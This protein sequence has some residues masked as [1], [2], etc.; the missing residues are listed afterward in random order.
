M[1]FNLR[2]KVAK[3]NWIPLQKKYNTKC[4]TFLMFE[5]NTQ[6]YRVELEDRRRT[7]MAVV[8]AGL[9]VSR[10]ANI[11][12]TIIDPHLKL[13]QLD[14]T[15]NWPSILLSKYDLNIDY[16]IS[17]G[18]IVTKSTPIVDIKLRNTLIITQVW[19]FQNFSYRGF[20]LRLARQICVW[21]LWHFLH[22]FQKFPFHYT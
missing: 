9:L 19:L 2:G 8:H 18:I 22:L 1:R 21:L 13:T 12:T 3:H 10:A 17:N 4:N 20:G 7:N 11:W 14:I 15:T 6:E 5:I 16:L